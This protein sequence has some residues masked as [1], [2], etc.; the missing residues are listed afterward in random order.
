MMNPEPIRCDESNCA[1]HS[2]FIIHHSS[3]V[4]SEKGRDAVKTRKQK[5]ADLE[6]LRKDIEGAA[7]AYLV[8]FKGMT[9]AEDQQLRAK[10][11]EAQIAYKVVKNTLARKAVEGTPLAPLADKFAGTTAMAYTKSDP[12]A[13]AKVLSGFAK[14]HA[15]FTF[16][17]GIV[18]GRVIDV[19]DIEKLATMPSKE[20]L[21][22]RIMMLIN[23]GAQRLATVTSGVARNLAIVIKE[24]K[25]KE[26]A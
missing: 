17:A 8:D 14:D 16:K 4:I 24:A 3:F 19:A 15:K 7:S 23:S 26:E 1:P 2:Q 5:Q 21:I 12:V 11:H 20:T 22:S 18:E 6:K 9:V 10:I 13:V 25:A